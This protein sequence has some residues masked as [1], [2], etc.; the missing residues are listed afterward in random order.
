VFGRNKPTPT[1]T[2]LLLDE[3]AESY[4]HFKQAAG[5]VAGGAAEKITPSYDRAV[6]VA[7]RGWSTTKGAFTPIYDQVKVGAANARREQEMKR[8]RWPMLVG[9]LAAGAAVGAAG[10]MVA[11]RRRTAAQWDEYEPMSEYED[12]YPSESKGESKTG[13][14]TQKVTAGAASVAESVSTG[15]GKL[16]ETLHEKSKTAGSGIETAAQ[17]AGDLASKATEKTG[18]AAETVKKGGNSFSAFA[19]EKAEDM[20]TK[21]KNSRPS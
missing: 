16:A 14:A 20:G 5:H 4:G 7:S 17:K 3:L 11:R 8:N 15:A 12:L 18:D 10:A 19:E 2:Q 13:S 21:S 6:N 1:Q 9:L